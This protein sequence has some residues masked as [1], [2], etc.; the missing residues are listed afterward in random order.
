M[1][2]IHAEICRR[3]YFKEKLKPKITDLKLSELAEI[4]CRNAN[5]KVNELSGTSRISRIVIARQIL[6]YLAYNFGNHTLVKI[7]KFIKKD[8][9]TIMYSK[10]K[11][12]TFLEIKD[13]QIFSIL[14]KIKKEL[15]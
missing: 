14:N 8:H 3:M 10:L 6:C 9:T 12:E 4:V 1:I 15:N 7:A 13:D 11:I 5:A 2:E